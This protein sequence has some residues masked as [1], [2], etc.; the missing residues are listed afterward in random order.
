LPAK[1]ESTQNPLFTAISVFFSALARLMLYK[2]ASALG[3]FRFNQTDFLRLHLLILINLFF[4]NLD[5]YLTHLCGKKGQ[6]LGADLFLL[7]TLPQ[8]F[9]FAYV[10]FAFAIKLMITPTV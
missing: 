3:R 9:C 5:N 8:I 7:P 4:F 1:T 6:A 2:K 10:L